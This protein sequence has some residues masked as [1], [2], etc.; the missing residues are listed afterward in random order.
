MADLAIALGWPPTVASWVRLT[1]VIAVSTLGFLLAGVLLID[2]LR[3]PA[4]LVQICSWVLWLTWL[5]VIF[6]RRHHSDSRH[7]S[8]LP[9]RRAFIRE[10]LPGI[11][12]SFA[13]LLRPALEGALTGD[14]LRDGRS[15]LLGVPLILAG[16]SL[17]VAGVSVLGVA[18]TLFVH[19]YVPASDELAYHGIYRRIRHPLFLGGVATSLGTAFCVGTPQA[20]W[21]AALSVGVLPIY[22]LLEDRRCCRVIGP[23]YI[24]YRHAVG[25]IFPRGSF[26]GDHSDVGAGGSWR[27]LVETQGMRLISSMGEII[28]RSSGALRPPDPRRGEQLRG[29]C[30]QGV[31]VPPPARHTQA[32]SPAHQARRGK[33]ADDRRAA[34]R[35]RLGQRRLPKAGDRQA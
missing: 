6:P 15:M 17:I 24:D 4:E 16:V 27:G 34:T 35:A 25:A 31:S 29:A 11:A 22:V 26:R 8:S 14:P 13:Q 21:L 30:D 10:I 18:S 23:A 1:A 33:P 7:P 5:G 3:L 19:E 9:Y 28:L 32:R 20:I 12:C 2:V